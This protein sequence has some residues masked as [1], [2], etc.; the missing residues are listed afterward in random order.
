MCEQHRSVL[1]KDGA[2]FTNE[3]KVDESNIVGLHYGTRG[4]KAEGN[5]FVFG[6]AQRNEPSLRCYLEWP[7]LFRIWCLLRII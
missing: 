7:F 6:I 3:V 5:T 4:R 1:T 2:P